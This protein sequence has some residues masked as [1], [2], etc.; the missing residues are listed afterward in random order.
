[1][2]MMFACC[3]YLRQSLV[4]GKRVLVDF[5]QTS[6]ESL[7]LAICAWIIWTDFMVLYAAYFEKCPKFVR[8][9]LRT[10][11]S[12]LEFR[13]GQSSSTARI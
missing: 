3:Q 9:E 6:V 12:N 13:S 4:L 8:S 7:S 1:M 5:L 10:V 2:L 11:V